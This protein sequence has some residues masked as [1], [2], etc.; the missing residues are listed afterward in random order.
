[1]L[2]LW[3]ICVYFLRQQIRT[4]SR[5]RA[6]S[7]FLLGYISLRFIFGTLYTIMTTHATTIS[8]VQHRDF[9]GG[10]EVYNNF[11]LFSAPVSITNT[12]SY[13]FS[14][15]M[16]E[17]LSLWRLAVLYHRSPYTKLVVAFPAL[18]YLSTIAMGIMLIIQTAHPLGSLWANGT[19]NFALP[20]FTLS[21]SMTVITTVIM[22]TWLILARRRL[23]HLL[24][25]SED[26]EPY[27]GIAAMLCESCALY[28]IFS[29]IFIALYAVNNPVQYVFFASLANVQ[30]I[31]PLLIIFRVSQGRVWTR[32]TEKNLSS[33]TE[34]SGPHRSNPQSVALSSLE[35]TAPGRSVGQYTREKAEQLGEDPGSI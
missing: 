15:W 10:P 21:V 34:R 26:S 22:I 4:G 8:Y 23:Q 13:I 32:T 11:V 12:I 2:T 25:S 6:R 17:A 33:T 19:L 5:D 3:V 31:A 20:Y 29:L 9:S 7:A 35:F 1:M 16:A 30:I 14:N 27:I 28:S 18:I 24:G